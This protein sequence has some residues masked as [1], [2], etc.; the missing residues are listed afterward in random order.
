MSSSWL[1]EMGIAFGIVGALLL[2]LTLYTGVW[3]PLV[4][5]ESGSMMHPD[6]DNYGNLGTIDPGDLVLVKDVGDREEIGLF[7]DGDDGRYG[8]SGDVIVYYPENDRRRTPIIHRAMTWVTVPDDG[9]PCVVRWFDG[10]TRTCDRDGTLTIDRWGI[11]DWNPDHSGFITL[12]DNND[13][14]DQATGRV[15]GAVQMEWVQ[16]MARGEIPWIGLIKL[17]VSP[18][19]NQYNAPAD[20]TRVGNAYAPGDLWVMLGVSLAGLFL[21]PMAIEVGVGVAVRGYRRRGAADGPGPGPPPDP[22]D[23]G[24]DP[25]PGPPPGSA[26]PDPDEPDAGAPP[27]PG[28]EPPSG[29]GDD[30]PAEPRD[31][32]RGSETEPGPDDP[33]DP[34]DADEAGPDSPAEGS[35]TEP[36]PGD[37]RS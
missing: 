9:S 12:G 20:W 30:P 21:A 6:E 31:A 5:V 2:G 10:G 25:A 1:K 28:G 29:S 7:V 36:G 18:G 15:G 33:G 27:E 26:D 23:D 24:P 16:G 13:Q 32:S 34:D 14:A 3:P 11:R 19:P 4:V 17:V 35:E 22:G 8:R 37:P